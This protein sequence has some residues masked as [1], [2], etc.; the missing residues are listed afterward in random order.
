ML[1]ITLLVVV[2]ALSRVWDNVAYQPELP[3]AF[4]SREYTVP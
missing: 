2:L 4:Q 1:A 3:F